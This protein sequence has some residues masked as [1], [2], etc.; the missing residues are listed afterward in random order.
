MV[1]ES[2]CG[3]STLARMVTLMEPPTGGRTADRR[4]ADR[5]PPASVRTPPLRLNVQMVFQNPYGSLNPRKTVG[6]ILE[7][8]LAINTAATGP[9]ANAAARAMM[10][11]RRAAARTSTAAIRTCSRAASASA[12]PSPAR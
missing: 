11:A 1:G 5:A 12:S 8:P 2:G 3:K 10:D 7:E 6:A 4:Q 9:R